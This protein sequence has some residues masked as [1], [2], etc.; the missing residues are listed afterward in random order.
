MAR[1]NTTQST[2]S[3]TE[4]TTLTYVLDKSTILL[5]GTAGYTLTLS[6]PV[7]FPGTIQSIYNS[8][9]GN[10]TIQTSA[11]NIIGNGFTAATTQI[12]PNNTTY[13]LTSNGTDYIITNNQ[14]GPISVTAGTFS[15]ALTANST[16]SLSPANANVTASPTGSG[17][18][19]IAPATAGTINN[20]AI[21]G[22]TRGAGNFTTLDANAAVGLSPSNATVTISPTG[23][24]TVAMSP[25]TT[26]NINN[27]NI[28]GTTR[29]AGAFTT[30]GSNAQVTMTGG[31][32][33][34]TTGTGQVVV[35]GGVGVSENLNVGGTITSASS[36][37]QNTPI[38]GT[39]RAAGAFTTLA[40]NSTITMSGAA[41]FSSTIIVPEPSSSTHA[42]SKNYVD[43]KISWSTPSTIYLTKTTGSMSYAF[44]AG[45]IAGD[46][47]SYSLI[48]GSVPAGM[49]LASNGLL[50]GTPSATSNTT[51]T[52][53]LRATG[54]SPTQNVD[55]AF[56]F[57]LII[58]P[59]VGQIL[60]EGSQSGTNGGV[61]AYT[62]VA[63]AGVST[64]S[65][66]VIGAGG[67]GYYGWAVCGGSGGGMA[68][69]AG[70]PVTPG[71][72]YTV[73]VGD[74]GCWSGNGGGYSCFPNFMGGGGRCGCCQGCCAY[75]GSYTAACGSSGMVAYP[76]TAG[77]GGGAGGYG[78]TNCNAATSGYRGCYGGGGS[79]TS[80]HS[81]THGTGGGGGT[82]I[83]GQG[84]DGACGNPGTG[85]GT[86]GGAGQGGS[87]G[88]CGKYGEPYSNGQGNGFACG[89]NYGGGGGGGGT[90]QGGGW[91]GKGAVRIIWGPGRSYP[92]TGTANQ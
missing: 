62:W 66:A 51:Y 60:Y 15:G 9:G 57:Y 2:I 22:T 21:G 90:G 10:V 28:G 31:T 83:L 13:T 74:G 86:S 4:A 63:P 8:T 36:G 25:A 69:G 88:T 85:H 49:S 37:I 89:G 71:S 18:V 3:V 59:P 39:T 52:F 47:V 80:H 19:T 11:G 75:G 32:T 26:G 55:R 16:V 78:P 76:D 23:T 6:T 67:G 7:P 46:S 38:G 42:A 50:S 5:S 20:V 84:T 44:A 61:T 68:W 58:P 81:S 65:V 1:F 34:T 91:G 17:T 56:T 77:G 29:A 12:I 53:T 43:T 70:I 30:L 82:G 64:V 35:T 40:A 79:A 54:G 45:N 73:Q 72:S 87:G 27:T 14:G 92:S 41:T 48:S 24:G 33:S